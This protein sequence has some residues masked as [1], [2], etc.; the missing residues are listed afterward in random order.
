MEDEKR[1]LRKGGE[2]GNGRRAGDREQEVNKD[3]G[4]KI[5]EMR[6]EGIWRE[7]KAGL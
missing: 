7:E 2:K 3:E 5:E 4:R 6:I 1:G